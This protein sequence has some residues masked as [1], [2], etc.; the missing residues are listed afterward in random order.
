[1]FESE[2]GFKGIEYR[3]YSDLSLLKLGGNNSRS[4]WLFD[5]FRRNRPVNPTNPNPLPTPNQVMASQQGSSPDDNSNLEINR[6]DP[7]VSHSRHFGQE[8]YYDQAS[9]TG[10]GNNTSAEER[11]YE[12]IGEDTC[13]RSIQSDSDSGGDGGGD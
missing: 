12:R 2:V 1:M 8:A 4:F 6:G 11:L 7:M 3:K 10:P 13:E 5:L 9:E